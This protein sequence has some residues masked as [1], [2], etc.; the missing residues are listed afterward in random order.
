MRRLQYI[1][2][3]KVLN[4][5]EKVCE[6]YKMLN[7]KVLKAL[8]GDCII[9]SYGKEKKHNILI[10]GGQGRLCFRQL[11]T[12]ADDVEKAGNRI[13]LLILTHID[14]D[15]IDGILQLLSQKTFDFS[16]IE[17]IWFDF[18]KGLQDLVGINDENHQVSLYG[19]TTQISWKQGIDLEKKIQEEGIKRRVVT[20]LEK[21]SVGGAAI[22][23][24]SPSREV[25]KKFSEQDKNKEKEKTTT[26]IAYNNDYQKSIIELNQKEQDR[27]V[28]LTNKS[29]IACLFEYEGMSI[30]LLGDADAEEIIKSLTELGYS[31]KNK[32]KVDF[33]KIAHHASRHNTSNELIQILDCG[34][35]IISTQQ[36]ANGR[37][38]KECLSRIICNSGKTVNFYCNYDL[39]WN[40]VFTTEEFLKYDMK[41]LVLDEQGVDV[42]EK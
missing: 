5:V 33:C 2:K 20:K 29:S 16:T 7:I 31:E 36:T 22:T 12:Y 15:H 21:F 9:I 11:R 40:K 39:D 34:N 17:E 24:L 1:K 27:K 41:F 26:E 3:E 30:L 19:D 32:L 37:P 6:D 8:N 28:S 23:I 25:L 35:Y 13:D 38:S 4:D 42:G 18:G 10:D 14:S